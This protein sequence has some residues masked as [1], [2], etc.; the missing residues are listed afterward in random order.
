MVGPLSN[1]AGYQSVPRRRDGTGDW[2]VNSIPRGWTTETMDE[3]VRT[4]SRADFPRVTLLNGFCLMIDRRVIDAVG[5]F[6]ERLFPKGFGEEE[7]LCIRA[8]DAGFE[9][10]IA[11]HVYVHHSKSRSYSHDQRRRLSRHGRSALAEKHGADRVERDSGVMRHQPVL[12][13]MRRC[14]G[15]ALI[16]A[17]HD[18]SASDT[19]G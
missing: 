18:P 6:D 7:D 1:A 4:C 12:A 3:I 8:R 13:R 17:G 10:A 19:P 11:D 9:L 15:N 14:V 5:V 16:A 2:A